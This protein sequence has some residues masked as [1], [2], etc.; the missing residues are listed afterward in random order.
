MIKT[1]ERCGERGEISHTSVRV[2]LLQ[3]EREREKASLRE[4]SPSL[5]IVDFKKKVAVYTHVYVHNEPLRLG[6]GRE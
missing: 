3:Q 4:R 2:I 5:L 6:T 1:F